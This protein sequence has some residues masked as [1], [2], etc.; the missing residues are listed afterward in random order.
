VK[1]RGSA[2]S[3]PIASVSS[4]K[5]VLQ[6]GQS[7][8]PSDLEP[9]VPAKKDRVRVL[10]APAGAASTGTVIGLDGPDAVVRLDDTA[11]FR[12]VPLSNLGR[13]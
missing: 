6:S 12:I 4:G 5:V 1:P 9:A 11:S 3:Q 13:L 7:Y 8:R 2:E 10:N